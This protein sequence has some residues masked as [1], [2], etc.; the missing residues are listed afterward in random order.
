MKQNYTLDDRVVFTIHVCP[1]PACLCEQCN[2][3]TINSS[4]VDQFISVSC[5]AFCCGWL[6]GCRHGSF[7]NDAELYKYGNCEFNY[8]AL[9]LAQLDY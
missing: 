5:T 2:L 4:H 3:Y 8:P 9:K 7:S 6:V 1:P